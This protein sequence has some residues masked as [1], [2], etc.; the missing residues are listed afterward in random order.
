MTQKLRNLALAAM[1]SLTAATQAKTALVVIV[2]GSPS[3][4]WNRPALQIDS[5]L[6]QALIPGFHYKRVAFM[7]FAQPDI[8][9]VFDDCERQETDTVLA[10][11]LFIAP[12]GHSEDDVPNLLGLKFDP[13]TRKSLREE[14]ARFVHTKM[15]TVVGPTLNCGSIIEEIMLERIKH[16][17]KDP[18]NEAVL[19]FSH[20]DPWRIGFWKK[21]LKRNCDKVTQNTAIDYTDSKLIAMGYTLVDDIKPMAL[22]A[23]AKKKRIILQG[24]Y[25]SSSMV[26]LALDNV[27]GDLKQS[28]GLN[29]DTE[30]V[31]SDMGIIPASSQ[32][33]VDWIRDI[34]S[35][36]RQDN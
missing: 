20:G 3:A 19:L 21:L 22:Q 16:L 2:H 5:M 26:D 10:L 34:A 27:K 31:V 8:Q 29:D 23:Q 36:W 4:K 30:L 9:A 33:V 12:S 15:H 18:K 13:E 17:S 25:L 6:R 7:E 24:I 11:P 32:R 28:L 1:L 14:N 35:Q